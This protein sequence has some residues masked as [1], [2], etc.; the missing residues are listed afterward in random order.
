MSKRAPAKPSYDFFVLEKSRFL[1]KT[2]AR[3]FQGAV[4][5]TARKY[6]PSPIESTDICVEI[7]YSMRENT[8]QAD[9]DAIIKP[10][11]A[12]LKGVAYRAESQIQSVTATFFDRDQSSTLSR[13]SEH[14][15]PFLFSGNQHIFL[16][17]IFSDT[18]LKRAG[19]AK[20]A[21]GWLKSAKRSDVKIRG[22]VARKSIPK[23]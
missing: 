14:L 1:G 6:I 10:V 4:K 16:I 18:Q 12:A 20:V 7:I 23:R 19:A 22:N 15:G 2:W 3:R 9:I 11:L 8:P 5:K 13:R 17:R 21:A